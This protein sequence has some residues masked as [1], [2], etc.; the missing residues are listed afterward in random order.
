MIA[1]RCKYKFDGGGF[2]RYVCVVG[3][4]REWQPHAQFKVEKV[5]VDIVAHTDKLFASI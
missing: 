4:G 1:S 3:G 2:G 5:V